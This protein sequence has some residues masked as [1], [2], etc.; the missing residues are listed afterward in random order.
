M[1]FIQNDTSGTVYA[2]GYFLGHEECERKTKTIPQ[3]MATT[4]A[5]GTKYVKAGTPFP[6]NDGSAVGIVYEDVDVTTG[7]MAGSVVTKGTVIESR[8]PVELAG[9][10]KTALAALG[11][12]FV[13]DGSVTRPY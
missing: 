7:D 10:A 2:A 6:S 8:L 12:T 13:T 4:A 9:T 11:F 3:S 1:S 5:N